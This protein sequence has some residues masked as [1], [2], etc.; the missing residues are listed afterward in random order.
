MWKPFHNIYVQASLDGMGERGDYMRKGQNWN[1]IVENR[2]K[3]LRDC[4]HIEFCVLATVSIMNV[5]HLPDF[6]KEWVE[7]QYIRP[8]EMQLNILFEAKYFNIRGLPIS[9]KMSVENKY[10]DFIDNYLNTLGE[11]ATRAR[12]YFESVLRYMFAE[13]LD[14]LNELRSYTQKLDVLRN[15]RFTVIFPEL[16]GLMECP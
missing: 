9:F 8:S 3:M 2:I 14:V 10:R 15:E 11:E 6:Y 13:Q 4:P 12:E 7:K 16:A 5:L 1:R